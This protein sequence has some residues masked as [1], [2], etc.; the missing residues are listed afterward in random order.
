MRVVVW[1]LFLIGALGAVAG[2]RPGGVRGRCDV[3]GA[4]LRHEFLFLT[5]M[6]RSAGSSGALGTTAGGGVVPA[7]SYSARSWSGHADAAHLPGMDCRAAHVFSVDE[8]TVGKTP[9]LV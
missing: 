3:R 7:D 1:P 8:R 6:A 2:A 4:C 9:R 5:S